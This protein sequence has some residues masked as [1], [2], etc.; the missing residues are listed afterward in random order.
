LGNFMNDDDQWIVE[1]FEELVDTYGRSYTAVVE[2]RVVVGDDPKKVED[3][4]LIKHPGKK[5]SVPIFGLV[6][7]VSLNFVLLFCF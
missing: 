5:L 3:E 4:A 1:H 7:Y 2:G 6:P